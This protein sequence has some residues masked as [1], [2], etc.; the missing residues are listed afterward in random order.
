MKQI[1][2]AALVSFIMGGA[3]AAGTLK[4]YAD[5]TYV[6]IDTHTAT[7]A[8]IEQTMRQSSDQSRIYAL[9]DYI[10]QIKRQAAREGRPLTRY[11]LNDI[12]E[13]QME[14]NKLT[15]W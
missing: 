9:Q 6:S 14:I 11:E 4:F 13:A 3:S 8:A 10:K 15:G 2:I 1:F 7:I 12:E 5:H